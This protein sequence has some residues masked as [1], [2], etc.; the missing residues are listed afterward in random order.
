MKFLTECLQDFLFFKVGDC[1]VRGLEIKNFSG[2][3]ILFNSPTSKINLIDVE[4]LSCNKWGVF[5]QSDLLINQIT[6]VILQPLKISGCKKG[7]IFSYD[8]KITARNIVTENNEGP[9]ILAQKNIYLTDVVSNSNKGPGIESLNGGIEIQRLNDES[10]PIQINGNKGMGLAAYGLLDAD[11]CEDD[12]A[13]FRTKP[14][15]RRHR[16]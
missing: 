3:G 14:P 15:R 10:G 5:S 8:G 9:G 1:T 4:I 11:H 12:E 16:Y 6:E 2:N 13:G 7:G